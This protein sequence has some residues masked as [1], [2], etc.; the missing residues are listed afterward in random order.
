MVNAGA[1]SRVTLLAFDT[2]NV[3]HVDGSILAN[4]CTVAATDTFLEVIIV[5]SPITF[6]RF[7]RNLRKINGMRLSAELLQGSQWF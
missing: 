2:V 3:D 4:R 6:G 7:Q 5:K 1:Q